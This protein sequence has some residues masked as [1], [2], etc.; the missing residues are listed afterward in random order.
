MRRLLSR[1]LMRIGGRLHRLGVSI[2]PKPKVVRCHHDP[3]GQYSK[4]FDCDY[5]DEARQL[6]NLA[7]RSDTEARTA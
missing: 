7:T 3:L 5:P 2:K 4:C 1:L 6:R